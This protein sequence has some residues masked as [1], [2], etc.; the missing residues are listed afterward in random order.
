MG[1]NLTEMSEIEKENQFQKL[2]QKRTTF[3]DIL[4]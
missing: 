4:G 3:Q 2:F 1:T